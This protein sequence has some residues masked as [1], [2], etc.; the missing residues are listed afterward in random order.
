MTGNFSWVFN[1]RNPSNAGSAQSSASRTSASLMPPPQ[2]ARVQNEYIDQPAHPVIRRTPN[3]RLNTS[4]QSNQDGRNCSNVNSSVS[5]DTGY[6]ESMH[7]NST[8]AMVSP[9]RPLVGGSTGY[10]QIPA[11]ANQSAPSESDNSEGNARHPYASTADTYGSVNS[12]LSRLDTGTIHLSRASPGSSA[13]TT[14]TD[15]GTHHRATVPPSHA[16][17][18]N[19][20]VTFRPSDDESDGDDRRGRHRGNG[21]TQLLTTSRYRGVGAQED[22]AVA[23]RSGGQR[24]LLVRNNGK[25]TNPEAVPLM[26]DSRVILEDDEHC[27]GSDIEFADRSPRLGRDVTAKDVARNRSLSELL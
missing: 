16:A 15:G 8:D 27:C 9:V 19:P 3:P 20:L 21:T 6:S 7:D 5:H 2:R 18:A 12:M 22:A 25:M 23:R 26:I 1:S 4:T 11:P 10:A 24:A 13:A 14:P 17:T